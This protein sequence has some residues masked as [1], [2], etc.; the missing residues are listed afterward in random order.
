[1]S[2]AARL[3]DCGEGMMLLLWRCDVRPLQQRKGDCCREVALSAS[4][5]CWDH[6]REG[7]LLRLLLGRRQRQMQSEEEEEEEE[8]EERRRWLTYQV[9]MPV[10]FDLIWLW[11]QTEDRFICL[12]FVDGHFIGIHPAHTCS[13]LQN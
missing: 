10:C 3:S 6:R 11:I 5:D 4:C 9:F 1:M 7:E 13:N 8:E 2:T 12:P